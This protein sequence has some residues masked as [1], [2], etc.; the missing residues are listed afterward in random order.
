MLSKLVTDN[1]YRDNIFLRL[2]YT[3]SKRKVRSPTC[4]D[5]RCINKR[6]SAKRR[7]EII[8]RGVHLFV[9]I[10]VKLHVST[11]TAAR[12]VVIMIIAKL[13]FNNYP[14]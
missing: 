1:V 4:A 5:T 2:I 8:G 11:R 9:L 7:N 13:H 6:S 10:V 12:N 14:K 3:F